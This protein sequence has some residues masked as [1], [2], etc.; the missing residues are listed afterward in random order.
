MKVNWV[1]AVM[2]PFIK[3]SVVVIVLN[4]KIL[5]RAVLRE[6][7]KSSPFNYNVVSEIRFSLTGHVSWD[8]Y[9]IKF[10]ASKGFN[11]KEIAEKI[12]NNEELKID[13]ESKWRQ[14]LF[15]LFLFFFYFPKF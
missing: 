13:E 1:T 7:T 14:L 2:L 6:E 4:Q 11:E 3:L 5:A 10:L 15:F 8:E 12:R 9:K